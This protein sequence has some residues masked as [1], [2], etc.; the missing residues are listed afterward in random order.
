MPCTPSPPSR[1]SQPATAT[2]SRSDEISSP[3]RVAPV[4]PTEPVGDAVTLGVGM[5]VAVGAGVGVAVGVGVG[6]GA[7]VTVVVVDAS[8][9]ALSGSGV[10]DPTLAVL[11]MIAPSAVP[12]ST[13]A[14]M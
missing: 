12:A 9:L 6:V 3:D 4:S 13:T 11:A 14:E 5:G 7:P 10:A 2:G 8:L 1:S